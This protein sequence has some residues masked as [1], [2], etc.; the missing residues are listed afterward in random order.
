MDDKNLDTEPEEINIEKEV[1]GLKINLTG[2]GKDGSVEGIKGTIEGPDNL[3]LID[4]NLTKD[5]ENYL[6][7]GTGNFIKEPFSA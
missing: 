6:I 7:T 2:Q 5:G 3:F 1:S 4:V